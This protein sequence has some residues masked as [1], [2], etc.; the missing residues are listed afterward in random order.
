MK[1]VPCVPLL[2]LLLVSLGASSLACQ[3]RN[4]ES[5][6]LGPE[7]VTAQ[8][9]AVCLADG[10]P[11][12]PTVGKGGKLV[13]SLSLGEVVKLTGDSEKD[14]AGKEYFKIELSDGKS[15]WVSNHGIVAS[16]QVAAVK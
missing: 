16:A 6:G 5:L 4:K 8:K 7:L 10:L 2:A 12:R 14:P 1:R 11:V 3:R 9:M 15:G 13:S